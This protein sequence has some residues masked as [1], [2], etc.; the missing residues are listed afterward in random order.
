[1]Q[2]ARPDFPFSSCLGSHVRDERESYLAVE[3][4]QWGRDHVDGT[5][6]RDP[7]DEATVGWA[8]D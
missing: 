4:N 3:A 1:M 2:G 6:T 8:R 5:I 7:E